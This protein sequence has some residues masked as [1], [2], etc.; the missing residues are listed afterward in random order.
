MKRK[1]TLEEEDKIIYNYTVLKYGRKKSG[2][3]FNLSDEAVK[4]L[5]INRGIKL[6]NFQESRHKKYE[7]DDT[8]FSKQSHDMAY[9]IGFLGADGNISSKDN[10]IDL[11]LASVD[12]EILVKIKEV[13]KLERDIKVYQC[14]SGYTKNKLYFYSAQIKQDLLKYGLVPNKTYSKD[15]HFPYLLD[16]EYIPD[17][18]RGL[19]DGDGSIKKNGNNICF[20]IDSSSKPI[21]LEIQKFLKE[22]YNIST[23]IAET[24]KLIFIYIVY[25]VIVIMQK[26]FMI[27]YIPQIHYS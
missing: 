3:E 1:L 10:R 12:Y 26:K 27:C 20:Q 22:N 8:Y 19:F 6:R 13:L 23:N 9:I 15:Y 16:K 14:S 7:M 18:I 2:K 25:T 11:E 5:L 4:K 24:K 17:Y 21:L